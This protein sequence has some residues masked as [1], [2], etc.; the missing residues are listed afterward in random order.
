MRDRRRFLLLGRENKGYEI[1]FF[2]RSY[3]VFKYGFKVIR[4]IRF[5]IGCSEENGGVDVRGLRGDKDG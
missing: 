4:L 1:G 3:R 5:Y 2:F